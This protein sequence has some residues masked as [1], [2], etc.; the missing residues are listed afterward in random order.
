MNNFFKYITLFSVTF[1]SSI[2]AAV[3][4]DLIL[5]EGFK[6]SIYA[7]NIKSARQIAESKDGNIFVGSKS[8]WGGWLPP[9]SAIVNAYLS[10]GCRV[11]YAN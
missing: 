4:E 6:I 1:S 10:Q 3:I 7:E 9:Q 11:A 8:T 5:P 2:Y